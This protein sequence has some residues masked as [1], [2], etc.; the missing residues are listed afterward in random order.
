MFA[1]RI[2]ISYNM[3]SLLESLNAIRAYFHI[4]GANPTI[5]TDMEHGGARYIEVPGVGRIYTVLLRINARDETHD[6]AM[7]AIQERIGYGILNVP[8]ASIIYVDV[9]AFYHCKYVLS[10][11]YRTNPIV[12]WWNPQ[13]R[14]E[15]ITGG[16]LFDEPREMAHVFGNMAR[17][18]K[19][20]RKARQEDDDGEDAG[21]SQ[22]E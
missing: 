1:N 13:Q 12:I 5:L 18:Q 14:T 21:S 2:L 20:R 16:L 22:E 9:G 4:P 15:D 17:L 10:R 3:R 11:F 7:D 6:Q 8:L 19:G